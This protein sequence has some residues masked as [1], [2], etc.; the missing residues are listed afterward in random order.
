MARAGEPLAAVATF[1]GAMPSPAPVEKGTVKP[2]IL[3]QTG[4]AD[5]MVPPAKVEAFAQELKDAGASVDVVVY[6][7]AKHSFTVPTA[8]KVGMDGLRYDPDAARKSWARMIEF[9]KKTLK[10]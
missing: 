10:P 5:P 6:P 3:I 9:F 8:D 1:H 2:A 7:G 4:G